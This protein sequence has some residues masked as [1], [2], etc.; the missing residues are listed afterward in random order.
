[1]FN[2]D[3]CVDQCHHFTDCEAVTFFTGAHTGSIPHAPFSCILKRNVTSH[4]CGFYHHNEVLSGERCAELYRGQHF[5]TIY[6]FFWKNAFK[7]LS[8]NLI[9]AKTN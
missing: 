8:I 3:D 7:N 4:M 6:F 1:M 5:D 9:L 2:F